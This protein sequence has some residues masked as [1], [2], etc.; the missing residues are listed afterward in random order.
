MALCASR[1]CHRDGEMR[2]REV[3]ETD[4]ATLRNGHLTRV[5]RAPVDRAGLG[6]A[7]LLLGARGKH[8]ARDNEQAAGQCAG[9]NVR[10]KRVEAAPRAALEAE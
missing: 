2:G 4:T 3:P 7:L 10:S 1:P 5:R 6:P 8:V 9:V